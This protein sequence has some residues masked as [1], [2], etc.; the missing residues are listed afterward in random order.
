[1]KIVILLSCFFSMPGLAYSQE[2]SDSLYI[3]TYTTGPTWDSNLSPDKQ[4][5][6]K[7]HSAHLSGLR[8]AG[9]IVLGARFAEKGMI[10]LSAKSF[11]EAKRILFNDPA[12]ENKLF[13]IDLQKFNLFY[14]G[15]VE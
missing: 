3:A 15:C 1:M 9:V 11:A 6:F 4:A 12:I 7:E 14:P 2:K 13:Q 8:K 10:V 5:Y